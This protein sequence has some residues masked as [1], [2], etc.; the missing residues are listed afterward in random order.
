MFGNPTG[1]VATHETGVLFAIIKLGHSFQL[2]PPLFLRSTAVT[3]ERA[4]DKA[5]TGCCLDCLVGRARLHPSARLWWRAGA[6]AVGL[7]LDHTRNK[8][9]RFLKKKFHIHGGLNEI[10]LQNF[11]GNEYNFSQRI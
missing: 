3:G 7:C 8:H 11:F 6:M 9:A 5:E 10:Y 2:L 1:K 4:T